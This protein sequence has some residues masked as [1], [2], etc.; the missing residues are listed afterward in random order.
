MA[1]IGTAGATAEVLG[2]A[3]A[4]S[5]TTTATSA[6]PVAVA[7]GAFLAEN[8]EVVQQIEDSV[9]EA[10]PQIENNTADVGSAIVDNVTDTVSSI[11]TE[12]PAGFSN[13]TFGQEVHQNFLDALTE[14]TSTAPSDWLMRT[15]PGLNGVDAEFMGQAD[16]NPGFTFAELKPYTQYGFDT[17]M[18][19]LDSWSLPQGQTQLWFYNENGIIGSS[20]FNY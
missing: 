18:N 13:P 19:Q 16:L 9:A 10:G 2:A 15:G 8:P 17:F 12:G 5:L 11:P 3:T 4:A 14:Q 6:A 1:V 20:G 7:G